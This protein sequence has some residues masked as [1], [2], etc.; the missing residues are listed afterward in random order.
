M[1]NILQIL[2]ALSFLLSTFSCSKKQDTDGIIICAASSVPYLNFQVID[3]KNNDLFF[4]STS[5]YQLTDIKIYYKNFN[6]KID[7]IMPFVATLNAQK[8]L[9]FASPRGK[10]PDTCYI[11]IK[12][13]KLDTIIYTAIGEGYSNSKS[14]INSVKINNSTPINTSL[15]SIVPIKINSSGEL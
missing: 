15:N 12:S 4:A 14:Y 5:V 11:K 7:S 10:T 13:L 9:S 1:K 8:Y 6:Q 3:Q 2:V